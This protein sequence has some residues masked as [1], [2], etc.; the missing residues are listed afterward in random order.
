MNMQFVS[1]VYFLL[2]VHII[3]FNY[4][5]LYMCVVSLV[6][7]SLEI[8]LSAHKKFANVQI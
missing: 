7:V 2:T 6:Y 3:T 5:Y 8:K 4:T 1:T